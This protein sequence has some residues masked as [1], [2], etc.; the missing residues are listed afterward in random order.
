MKGGNKKF[1]MISEGVEDW[2]ENGKE[3][4]RSKKEGMQVV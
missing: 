3:G 1:K 4:R 2:K